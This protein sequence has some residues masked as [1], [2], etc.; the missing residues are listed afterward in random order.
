[1]NGGEYGGA[2][3]LS[4]AAVAEMLQYQLKGS[5]RGLAWDLQAPATYFVSCGDRLIPGHVGQDPG[6]NGIA[7]FLPDKGTAAIVLVN[8]DLPSNLS[9]FSVNQITGRL[10]KEI[11]S[12]IS[13]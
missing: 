11:E 10:L 6:F 3:I 12:E 4:Q 8:T 9:V 5:E 1:L 7:F 2:Q 13:Q